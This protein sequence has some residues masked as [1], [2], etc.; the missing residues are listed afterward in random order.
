MGHSAASHVASVPADVQRRRWEQ[1]GASPQPAERGRQLQQQL[2]AII[3]LGALCRPHIV[4]K[5]A[6]EVL[7]QH[8][9]L[10]LTSATLPAGTPPQPAAGATTAVEL[11]A[12]ALRV[13]G[14]RRGCFSSFCTTCRQA[15]V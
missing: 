5:L 2:N 14:P 9:M 3:L 13:L 11:L 4:V 12:V 10:A 7:V 8:Q 1:R 6:H 15:E